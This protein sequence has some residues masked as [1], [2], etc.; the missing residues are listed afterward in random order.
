[1]RCNAYIFSFI[2]KLDE[3]FGGFKIMRLSDDVETDIE[4]SFGGKKIKRLS[5]LESIDCR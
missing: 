2:L 5:V 3:D 1:L 4:T